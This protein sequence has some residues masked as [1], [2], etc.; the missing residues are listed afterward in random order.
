MLPRDDNSDTMLVS[1]GL[2]EPGWNDNGKTPSWNWRFESL[3]INRLTASQI[4]QNSII[5][6]IAIMIDCLVNHHHTL[7]DWVT[8]FVLFVCCK[9]MV[10]CCQEVAPNSFMCIQQPPQS[11]PPVIA[12]KIICYK[13]LLGRMNIK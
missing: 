2:I 7:V 9:Y 5:I 1:L 8:C 4:S 10:W 11:H 12:P 3:I 6:N 13:S